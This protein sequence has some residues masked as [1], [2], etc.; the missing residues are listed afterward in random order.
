MKLMQAILVAGVM[1]LSVGTTFGEVVI[2]EVPLRWEQV[3]RLDG[4]EI[5]SNLC[6]VCH[7]AGGTG[8]GPAVSALGKAVPDLTVLATNNGG[9][10]PYEYVENVIFGKSR[11]IAHG[12]IDMPDWGEHFMYVGSGVRQIP[13]KSY[14]RELTDRL[15]KHVETL[16]V[17]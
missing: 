11:V 2:R 3:A 8:D 9:V 15:N 12:T 13:S 16:Q 7:G 6:A 14:A 17:N 4:D 5:F 1:I 10:Y